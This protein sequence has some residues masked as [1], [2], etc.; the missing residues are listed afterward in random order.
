[1]NVLHVSSAEVFGGIESILVSLALHRHLCPG[2]EHHFALSVEGRL[3]EELRAA[4]APVYLLGGARLNR[5]LRVRRARKSLA[6]AIRQCGCDV[7]VC[8]GPRS[9]IFFAPTVRDSRVPLAWWAHGFKSRRHYLNA[10]LRRVPPD[11]AICCSEY[12]HQTLASLF[13]SWESLVIH[14]PIAMNANREGQSSRSAV[15]R[16]LGVHDDTTVIALAGRMVP[17]KGHRSLIHALAGLKGDRPWECWIVGGPQARREQAY[18][19][20]LRDEARH[21]GLADR[22]HFL[23]QRAD[24]PSI[25]AAAD[26]YCQPN[27]RGDS[28]AIVFIEAMLAG[29]PVV[30]SAAGGALEAIDQDSGILVRPGDRQ[31]LSGALETLL[32]DP[33]LR[34]RLGSNGPARARQLCDPAARLRD[35]QAA[36]EAVVSTRKLG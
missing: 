31:A 13:P 5:P 12:V 6:S 2:L 33:V 17:Y 23:G 7:A 21:I 11:L 20:S 15:R 24:V 18:F 22:I 28:F 10:L 19:R 25:L 9:L 4:G 29:L 3:S 30:T 27:L 35:L 32:G 34:Q 16:E 8:H 1:V 26:L 14:A 36:L